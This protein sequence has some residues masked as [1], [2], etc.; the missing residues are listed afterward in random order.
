MQTGGT[1]TSMWGP[2]TGE[3]VSETLLTLTS[4]S[5]VVLSSLQPLPTLTAE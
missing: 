4:L 3:M 1:Q 5:F 2:G